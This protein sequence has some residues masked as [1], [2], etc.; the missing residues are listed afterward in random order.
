MN[1]NQ[2]P[3]VF[4]GHNDVLWRLNH[5]HEKRAY[6]RF[7]SGDEEGHLDLPRMKKGGFGGGFF[8]IYVPSP[9]D[10]G[11]HHDEMKAPEYDLPLP[12]QIP[13]AEALPAALRAMASLARIERKSAGALKICRS[14][15]QIRE[16]IATGVIAAVMHFEGAEAIDDEF[17]A[18]EVLYR[19]G[20]RSL[21]PVWSR[22]TIYGHGVPFRFPSSPDTGP[23]LTDKGKAL[24]RA[25]N[26]LNMM[27]DVSHITEKGFWDIAAISDAP[28]VAT[29]SNAHAVCPHSRNLTDKQLTA[30]GE[31]GGLV[32][33]NFATAFI[34]PDGRMREDTP[35]DDLLRHMDHLIA[36][37]GIEGVGFGSDFDGAQ[38]PAKIKDV[39]GLTTLRRAMRR[40]GYDEETMTRL[41]HGNWLRVLEK[42]FNG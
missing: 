19:A 10:E 4:D 38:V 12:A 22:P 20:L 37:A 29:H 7:L 41:C 31:S 42:T 34:R 21:A 33:V 40:H 35:L 3:A 1:K 23:G 14:A 6:R 11:S 28:L 27:V 9:E 2:A 36:H 8:V 32:G 5:L 18:L 16:C 26:E 39:A 30:I 24:V 13:Y 15:A 25:C 17:D